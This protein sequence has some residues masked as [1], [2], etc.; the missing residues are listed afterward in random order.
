[1]KNLFL[2]NLLIAVVALLGFS[3]CNDD[4]EGDNPGPQGPSQE[5]LATATKLNTDIES[6]QALVTAAY[7]ADAVTDIVTDPTT[8][9]VQL[10]LK[11]G[12]KIKIPAGTPNPKL[13]AISVA[14]E[15]PYWTLIIDGK[16]TALTGTA[17]SYPVSS[18]TLPVFSVTDDSEWALNWGGKR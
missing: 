7:E 16:E 14:G 8:S 1:M 4:P 13:P 3:A 15:T 2:R 6:I 11:S 9:A 18:G 12:A 17:D 10:S 5:L